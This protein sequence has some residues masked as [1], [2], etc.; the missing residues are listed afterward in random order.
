MSGF[1]LIVSPQLFFLL[2]CTTLR[3]VL[4]T[5]I[6]VPLIAKAEETAATFD[7]KAAERF[8]NLALA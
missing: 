5:I 6:L 2:D 7:A 3:T 4:A 8:A 1:G